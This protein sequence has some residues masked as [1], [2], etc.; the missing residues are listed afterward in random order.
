MQIKEIFLGN[1]Q[2]MICFSQMYVSDFP[3]PCCVGIPPPRAGSWEG[4][5]G[6]H[7]GLSNAGLTLW[8]FQ[9]QKLMSNKPR[10]LSQGYV[11]NQAFLYLMKSVKEWR[12]MWDMTKKAAAVEGTDFL[13]WNDIFS[14]G[15]L[16]LFH[17]EVLLLECLEQQW[18]FV[19]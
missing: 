5:N 2:A 15:G 4:M 17:M 16:N 10:D 13:V 14:N 18:I 11:Q 12:N 3:W 6:S 8:Q 7:P 19:A 1:W 9:Q